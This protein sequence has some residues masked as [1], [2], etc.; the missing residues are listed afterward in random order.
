[1]EKDFFY[2]DRQN[3]SLEF[4]YTL[5]SIW[6]A[7][8]KYGHLNKLTN[9]IIILKADDNASGI[10]FTVNR[11]LSKNRLGSTSSIQSTVGGVPRVNTVTNVLRRFFSRDEA[12]SP[13]TP[14]GKKIIS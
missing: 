3:I 11:R 7:Y 4:Y 12:R 10:H 13:S 8:K 1:M 9:D 14:E 5:H 2:F 6:I